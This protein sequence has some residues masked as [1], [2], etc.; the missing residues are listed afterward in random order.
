MQ[1]H[2]TFSFTKFEYFSELSNF[3]KKKK[4]K[5]KK[6]PCYYVL[7][8]TRAACRHPISHP[9]SGCQCVSTERTAGCS[10]RRCPRPCTGEGRAGAAR[11]AAASPGSSGSCASRAPSRG[12]ARQQG[13][14]GSAK[15]LRAKRKE[16]VTSR[17]QGGCGCSNPGGIQGQ[18]G[19]GSGQRGLVVGDPAHSRGAETTWSL[20]SFSTQSILWFWFITMPATDCLLTLT[21]SATG[22]RACGPLGCRIPTSRL[23]TC[24]SNAR[25]HAWRPL[26]EQKENFQPPFHTEDPEREWNLVTY[27]INTW[28][29]TSVVC[30]TCFKRQCQRTSV[31]TVPLFHKNSVSQLAPSKAFVCMC[32]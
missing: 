23:Q 18:A 21:S 15:W 13:L 11:P 17:P 14:R 2:F 12:Q 3:T 28:A 8:C 30:R 19:C 24:L 10:R 9:K 29:T 6:T 22:I 5:K 4:K 1:F 26:L 32:A 7:T 31:S 25:D 20:W 16:L 27:R